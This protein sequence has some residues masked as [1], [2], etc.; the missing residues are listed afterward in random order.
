MEVRDY[1]IT[2]Y[3]TVRI[4]GKQNVSIE[5]TCAAAL[6]AI[7]INVC[8]MSESLMLQSVD[9]CRMEPY[10]DGGVFEGSTS[11]TIV[12]LQPSDRTTIRGE[13]DVLHSVFLVGDTRTGKST[14]GNALSRNNEFTT[15]RGTTG[16]LRID[17]AERPDIVNGRLH[18]TEFYDTPGLNDKDGLD[19]LYES[20]IE[21]LIR[22]MSFANAIVMTVAVDQGLTK[23]MFSAIDSYSRLFG[24]SLS[25]MFILVMTVNYP[26]TRKQHIDVYRLNWPTLAR[27]KGSIVSKRHTFCISLADIRKGQDGGGAHM[28]YGNKTELDGNYRPR[29]STYA[30]PTPSHEVLEEILQICMSMEMQVI[31]LLKGRFNEIRE[32]FNSKGEEI[33]QSLEKLQ[34]IGWMRYES[35]SSQYEDA[36]MVRMRQ[37]LIDGFVMKDTD[38]LRKSF[39]I[40]N[41]GLLN[42]IRKTVVFVKPVGGRAKQ[43]WSTFKKKHAKSENES[44]LLRQ[45]GYEIDKANLGIYVEGPSTRFIGTLRVHKY[46]LFVFD[47]AKE[48][49]EHLIE[50]MIRVSQDEENE[51]K[52]EVVEDLYKDKLMKAVRRVSRR[53]SHMRSLGRSSSLLGLGVIPLTVKE[54]K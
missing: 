40:A 37:G 26:S 43:L 44:V 41:M 51:L 4:R 52:Q 21:D 1:D 17:R 2:G 7:S 50:H 34:D 48:A 9:H 49:Q 14:L 15:S 10:T 39:A 22:T 31:A 3:I 25:K 19:L 42:K 6:T 38:V 29:T 20:S 54:D 23:S 13:Y 32:G 5:N 45:L 27:L 35:I 36:P 16:T 12:L 28:A 18:L 24:D 33:E 8:G 11:K 30:M 53:K 46:C 47:P